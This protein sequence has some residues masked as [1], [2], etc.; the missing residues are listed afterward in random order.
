MVRMPKNDNAFKVMLQYHPEQ[1]VAWLLP[2]A[3][4]IDMLPAELPRESLYADALLRVRY[5]GEIYVLHIEIQTDADSAI[6]GR[7]LQY[8]AYIWLRYKLKVLTVLIY[9][10]PVTTVT[11]P[12]QL[13]GPVAPINTFHFQVARLWE[14]PVEHWL[15]SGN[16]SLLIFTPL[17]KDA[18]LAS[19]DQAAEVIQQAANPAERDNALNYLVLFAMRKFGRSIITNHIR[20]N[21]VL[22]TY[23]TQS[24]WY[25]EILQR[26]EE[27]GEQRGEQRGELR[28]AQRMAQRALE[29]RFG[30]VP[31]DVLDA[32]AQA[33][34]ATLEA[35]VLHITTDTIE[36]VRA[37]LGLAAQP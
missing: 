22:D 23:I 33:D 31:Q 28:G 6:L 9:L 29:G 21:P 27:R 16:L 34:E 20:G 14:E 11:S 7:M 2:G 32:L 15:Q 18:T 1:F 19:F 3:E 35:I 17:L 5:Q 24:E 10:E 13:D 4:Y 26:G 25:Q 37:R 30:T 12:W 36:Q 8:L